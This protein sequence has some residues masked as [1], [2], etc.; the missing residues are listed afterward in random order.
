MLNVNSRYLSCFHFGSYITHFICLLYMYTN[1]YFIYTHIYFYTEREID[2]KLLAHVIM[3]AVVCV[4][5]V[6][7]SVVSD[8]LQPHGL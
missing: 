1:I 2:F 4:L 6:S 3:A 8:S 5:C 7:Y